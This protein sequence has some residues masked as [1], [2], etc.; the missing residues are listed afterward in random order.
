MLVA[1]AIKFIFLAVIGFMN[2]NRLPNTK[3][4]LC[5]LALKIVFDLHTYLLFEFQQPEL[6]LFF[7][8]HTTP[9]GFLQ[10][11]LLF[12]YVRNTLQNRKGLSR[13]DVLHSLPFLVA[14][15]D[16]LPYTLSSLDTKRVIIAQI[17]SN[18][19]DLRVYGSGWIFSHYQWSMFR[20]LS[21]FIYLIYIVFLL[22]AH[23]PEKDR[24]LSFFKK[25][26]NISYVW[27]LTLS[28]TLA[29]LLPF[30]LFQIINFN[31]G[32]I[33]LNTE[34]Y[35]H[36]PAFFAGVIIYGLACLIPLF[37]PR[38]LYGDNWSGNV[39]SQPRINETDPPVAVNFNAGDIQ[40]Q[41]TTATSKKVQ[42]NS[43]VQ[44]AIEIKDYIDSERPYL[45]LDFSISTISRHL[46][47][48]EHQVNACFSNHFSLGFPAYRNKLRIEYALLLM[49]RGMSSE[50]T[51]D[52]IGTSAG[53]RSK[54]IFYAA[55]RK[56][57]G[58]T[59][60]A[61][62]DQLMSGGSK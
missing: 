36:A 55:F 48:P 38:I 40:S 52:A 54:P 50:L 11:P 23:R 29:C 22:Y 24:F 51:L 3:I 13:W 1:A 2:R 42:P 62:L 16:F 61:Y 15:A 34:S 26:T 56:E 46:Q 58:K 10:A 28:G 44:L 27:L 30:Y 39:E 53:F 31:L 45:D 35:T 59:P 14:L 33:D 20:W 19:N 60:G 41:T 49:Q 6:L 17:I 18:L 4:F 12:L 47:V 7:F 25:T 5:F 9:L 37:F 32:N 43:L 8:N 21:W 57:T